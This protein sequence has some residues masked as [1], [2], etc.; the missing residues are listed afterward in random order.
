MNFQTARVINDTPFSLELSERQHM[1]LLQ[2]W[3]SVNDIAKSLSGSAK[4][5]LTTESVLTRLDTCE[6]MPV[7]CRVILTPDDIEISASALMMQ[8][9]ANLVDAILYSTGQ[10]HRLTDTPATDNPAEVINFFAD[11]ASYS[12]ANDVLEAVRSSGAISEIID[13]TFNPADISEDNLPSYELFTKEEIVQLVLTHTGLSV[14]PKDELLAKALVEHFNYIDYEVSQ[15]VQATGS[16]FSTVRVK[17]DVFFKKLH[18]HALESGE[19]GG[20]EI[21]LALDAVETD[22]A[23]SNETPK[24]WSVIDSSFELDE[25][26]ERFERDVQ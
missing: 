3:R 13:D 14:N 18:E 19:I 17:R 8:N 25:V 6:S 4:L 2:A 26:F 1:Q 23:R 22:S 11:S 12:P 16:E 5:V 24:P 7:Q 10:L 15:R 9:E 21:L 20:N